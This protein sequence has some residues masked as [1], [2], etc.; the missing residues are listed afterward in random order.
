MSLLNII[1]RASLVLE[2]LTLAR[3]KTTQR[4][5]VLVSARRTRSWLPFLLC[6]SLGM[7]LAWREENKGSEEEVQMTV[8]PK[9]DVL[10]S[11]ANSW[12]HDLSTNSTRGD[13]MLSFS[14]TAFYQAAP[15]SQ[16]QKEMPQQSLSQSIRTTI[17]GEVESVHRMDNKA[18]DYKI[19]SHFV[20]DAS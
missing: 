3:I 15:R 11:S 19:T 13:E 2:R 7:D 6:V 17:V 4:M 9:C 14:R 18:R 8:R 1:T 12:F 5:V 10:N 20:L 16:K